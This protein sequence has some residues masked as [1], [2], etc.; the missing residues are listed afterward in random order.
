M[1]KKKMEFASDFIS[2]QR[3]VE[4]KNYDRLSDYVLR[5]TV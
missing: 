1:K 3:F 4:L 5:R 2:L